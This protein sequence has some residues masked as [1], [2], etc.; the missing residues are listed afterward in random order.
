MAGIFFNLLKKRFSKEDLKLLLFLALNILSLFIVYFGTKNP[1]WNYHFISVEV[2]FI[3]LT[4]LAVKKNRI[5]QYIIFSWAIL[6]LISKAFLFTQSLMKENGQGE[7]MV[8]RSNVE[9]ILDD[10]K[11]S[12]FTYYA[13]NASIYSYDYD[14][15]FRWIGE[16]KKKYPDQNPVTAV[17]TYIIIP[18]DVENDKVGFTLNRT[19]EEKYYTASQWLRNDGTMII[20]R[21]HRQ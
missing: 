3:F 18:E 6:L 9:F 13:K 14:Y 4:L 2:V 7:L 15:I 11:N 21:L 16:V 20:K 12:T 5:F 1:V 17:N 10:T 8:K 19:P